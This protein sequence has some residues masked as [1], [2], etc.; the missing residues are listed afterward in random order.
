MTPGRMAGSVMLNIW[1]NGRRIH[2]TLQ[3]LD[4]SDETALQQVIDCFEL[5]SSKYEKRSPRSI[6]LSGAKEV[7]QERV[8]VTEYDVLCEEK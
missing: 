5:N 2:R 1:M 3:H 4:V 8:I 7:H 6:R